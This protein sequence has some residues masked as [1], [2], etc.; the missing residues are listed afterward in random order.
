MPNTPEKNYFVQSTEL[1]LKMSYNLQLKITHKTVK[2][3]T[4]LL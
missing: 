2:L 4:E 1:L 3:H